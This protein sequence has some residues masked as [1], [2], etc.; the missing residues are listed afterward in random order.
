MRLPYSSF[1]DK[2]NCALFLNLKVPMPWR[3]E[4]FASIKSKVVPQSALSIRVPVVACSFQ[5]LVQFIADSGQP[6]EDE[7]FPNLPPLV[8][9]PHLD[10]RTI[11]CCLKRSK[12]GQ[13]L[14]QLCKSDVIKQRNPLTP[15]VS[16]NGMN[17]ACFRKVP[18]KV[19]SNQFAM[20]HNVEDS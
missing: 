19:L 7:S 13:C 10:C 8:H 1:S 20:K 12:L 17:G 4:N 2:K 5:C 14:I 6:F 16:G 15:Y 9:R 3:A 18:M 11:D